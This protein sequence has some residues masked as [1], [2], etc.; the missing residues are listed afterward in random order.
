MLVPP[1]SRSAVEK[2]LAAVLGSTLPRGPE[3][4]ATSR[5]TPLPFRLDQK[6]A[7][8]PALDDLR[9]AVMAFARDAHAAGMLSEQV[10]MQLKRLQMDAHDKSLLPIDTRGMRDDIVRWAIDGYYRS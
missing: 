5:L 8:N 7:P 6:S 10:L 9:A 2:A 1:E 3:S 4:H